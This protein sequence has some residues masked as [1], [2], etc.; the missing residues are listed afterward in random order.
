VVAG[1]PAVCADFQAKGVSTVDFA[2]ETLGQIVFLYFIQKKGWLG[3]NKS[4]LW[5]EGPRHFLRQLAGSGRC[6]WAMPV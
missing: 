5:G 1:N 4:Q 3:V 6:E 2:Q